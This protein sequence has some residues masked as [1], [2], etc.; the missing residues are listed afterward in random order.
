MKRAEDR[1]LLGQGPARG[2]HCAQSRE[3]TGQLPLRQAEVQ[4]LRSALRQHDVAGLEIAMD[5]S[6]PMGLVQRIGDLR[7]VAQHLIER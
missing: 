5:D 1:A 2:G 7:S 6:F 4:Q 3:R